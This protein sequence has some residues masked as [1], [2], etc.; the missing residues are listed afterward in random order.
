MKSLIG[1]FL[2]LGLWV[3][4]LIGILIHSR[5]DDILRHS[6]PVLFYPLLLAWMIVF[7]VVGGLYCGIR[8]LGYGNRTS[9]LLMFSAIPCGIVY[10][11]NAK[12]WQIIPGRLD[13]D[14]YDSVGLLLFMLGM[15]GGCTFA[16]SLLGKLFRKN[17][18]ICRDEA[19]PKRPLILISFFGWMTAIAVI[20]QFSTWISASWFI[21]E[22]VVFGLAGL[23][24]GFVLQLFI[25]LPFLAR[26]VGTSNRWTW[27]LFWTLFPLVLLTGLAWL[28][29][30]PWMEKLGSGSI[31]VAFHAPVVLTATTSS[32]FFGLLA[33]LAMG[34]RWSGWLVSG[35]FAS[36]STG[37]NPGN[38]LKCRSRAG[39]RLLLA[40]RVF[41]IGVLAYTTVWIASHVHMVVTQPD[42]AVC[43]RNYLSG[44]VGQPINAQSIGEASRLLFADDTVGKSALAAYSGLESGTFRPVVDMDMDTWPQKQEL[45]R[46]LGEDPLV[47][48]P[49]GVESM[50]RIGACFSQI[51][52]QSQFG[53]LASIPWKREWFQGSIALLDR[54]EPG[55]QAIHQRI[56]ELVA[57]PIFQGNA[58]GIHQPVEQYL[59]YDF[60]DLCLL[61]AM[62][63][64]GEG[65]PNQ[66]L[67]RLRDLKLLLSWRFPKSP[68]NSN[69]E[70]CGA[71]LAIS[72]HLM[73]CSDLDESEQEFVK[74]L[75]DQ[76][77]NPDWNRKDLLAGF[78]LDSLRL[79][80]EV[81]EERQDSFQ[82]ICMGRHAHEFLLKDH[83]DYMP[84]VIDWREMGR[85]NRR[86]YNR[87]AE[88]LDRSPGTREV[89]KQLDDEHNRLVDAEYTK[90][91]PAGQVLA[92]AGFPSA[93]ARWLNQRTDWIIQAIAFSV[94]NRN[95]I[96]AKARML[97]IAVALK[98]WKKESGSWPDNL[99]VLL[100][101]HIQLLP[102]DPLSGQAFVYKK[103]GEEFELYS[104]GINEVS[105]LPHI[106]F[107]PLK[108]PGDDAVFDDVT[109][110]PEQMIQDLESMKQPNQWSNPGFGG[111]RFQP[112]W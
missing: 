67:E 100:T 18:V 24:A 51:D 3:T 20:L 7:P 71:I 58:E 4:S 26:L 46:S 41:V 12:S 94:E 56:P 39:D 14:S 29:M 68:T 13:S 86:E 19:T 52:H 11:Y 8:H 112:R 23:F 109:T 62:N 85:Q 78:A 74:S 105:D 91:T 49:V 69:V 48:Q 89:W 99:E 42:A 22:F 96:A 50:D 111:P 21:D 45:Y 28:V 60:P 88:I 59:L 82:G 25:I 9:R 102:A 38:V 17:W 43:R 66:A 6:L 84:Q 55:F 92:T 70:L 34:Y 10:W 33:C 31:S 90:G 103:R 65:R 53:L 30:Q 83:L 5:M 15:L 98:A 36:Q 95:T 93:K 87:I 73:D 44:F 75:V 64:L 80:V 32:C 37:A 40:A 27:S 106:I 47:F 108:S 1:R 35:D 104:L 81:L 54:L 72:A 101:R 63:D 110:I 57:N 107:D 16:T 76:L 79:A 61:A 97:Q 77:A 2:I